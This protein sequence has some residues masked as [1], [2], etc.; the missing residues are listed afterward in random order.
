MQLLT[1]ILYLLQPTSTST[2]ILILWLPPPRKLPPMLSCS[3]DVLDALD[4][5]TNVEWSVSVQS[6]LLVKI[7]IFVMAS[8]LLCPRDLEL[9]HAG[10]L[11]LQRAHISEA[12]GQ[13][14]RLPS[15]CT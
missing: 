4:A 10:G 8:P 7:V 12:D 14:A 9:G 3:L 2:P 13:M 5:S 6:R 15:R 1:P 11:Q